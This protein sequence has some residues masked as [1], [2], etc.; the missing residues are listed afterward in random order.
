MVCLLLLNCRIAF[1]NTT[2]RGGQRPSNVR[3]KIANLEFL[4]KISPQL[5]FMH[6]PHYFLA[7]EEDTANIPAEVT[8]CLRQRRKSARSIVPWTWQSAATRHCRRVSET[9]YLDTLAHSRVVIANGSSRRG[10]N[11]RAPT[12]R[13]METMRVN[14]SQE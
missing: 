2:V 10:D 11:G 8:L 12:A 6:Y 13:S 1:F 9:L 14:G 5:H 3:L 7:H 4:I